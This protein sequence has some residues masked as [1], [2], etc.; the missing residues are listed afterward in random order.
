MIRVD[1]RKVEG[2]QYI[3][4]HCIVH[5]TVKCI[6]LYNALQRITAKHYIA[7][8]RVDMRKVEGLHCIALHCMHYSALQRHATLRA[9]Q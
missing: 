2:L 9:L 3:A 1:M 6:T 4:L 5:Y 7:M 8:I